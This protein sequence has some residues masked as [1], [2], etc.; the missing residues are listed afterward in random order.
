MISSTS[1]PKTKHQLIQTVNKLPNSVK[2]DVVEVFSTKDKPTI[3]KRFDQYMRKGHFSVLFI[4]G[5]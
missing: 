3:H 1:Q 2:F 4:R 5:N